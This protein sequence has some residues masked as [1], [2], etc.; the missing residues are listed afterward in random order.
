MSPKNLTLDDWHLTQRFEELEDLIQLLEV[1]D[2]SKS[3]LAKLY[4][5]Y[6]QLNDNYW[7]QNHNIDINYSGHRSPQ[8]QEQ[9]NS[10][11]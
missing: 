10:G 8:S 5:Q 1:I 9:N 3:E 11:L 7:D 2:T 6:E 4:Q